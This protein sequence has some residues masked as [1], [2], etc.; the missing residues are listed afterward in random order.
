MEFR[1]FNIEFHTII[2][3]GGSKK[4]E[5][6]DRSEGAGD[7]NQNVINKCMRGVPCV[8]EQRFNVSQEGLKVNEERSGREG[9]QKTFLSF[10]TERI[11]IFPALRKTVLNVGF[12]TS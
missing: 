11:F 9:I 3:G 5:H 1:F 6:C 8:G 10:E 12:F 4:F 7:A 2:H